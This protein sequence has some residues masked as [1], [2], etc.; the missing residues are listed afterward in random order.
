MKAAN[1]LEYIRKLGIENMIGVPDSTLK[2]LL[3]I[4]YS[5]KASMRHYVPVNEGAAV[6]MAAGVYL[7]TGRA[8]CVYMQNSGLGNAV[9]PLTSLLNWEVYKIPVLLLIGW[10][11][12]PGIPDEPQHKFM[13]R[14]TTEMLECLG[15]KFSMAG[16]GTTKEEWNL[17]FEMAG[18]AIKNEEAYAIVIRKNT[19]EKEEH[20]EFH[21]DFILTRENSVSEILCSMEKEDVVVSTTGKISREVYDQSERLFGNNN[22]NFLTVGGMGYASMIA[23][24]IAENLGEKRVYCL[25]GDGAVLMHMGNLSF[26]AGHNPSRFVH[27]CLNNGAYESV[28]GMPTEAGIK[29]YASVAKE[30]GYPKV[31]EVDT[32]TDLKKALSEI[33]VLNGLVFLE[34]KISMKSKG[35]LGRPKE[36]AEKNKQNFMDF[37]K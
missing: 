37:I 28:G 21:N 14:I 18:Q 25:D 10:R 11:G 22:R 34:V 1:F 29:S 36:R 3:E 20:K 16:S 2:E 23:F 30:C 8:A 17:I 13:G 4:L 35:E 7:S 6:G 19:F 24:G 31:F 12:E 26:I 5:D 32:I 27:I 15:I 33:K 9:N